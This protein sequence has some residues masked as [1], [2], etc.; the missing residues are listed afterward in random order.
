MT[1]MKTIKNVFAAAA[2]AG[3]F[4]AA[5]FAQEAAA[6][7]PAPPAGGQKEQGK[8]VRM[9]QPGSRMEFIGRELN[10]TD[11]QKAKIKAIVE[12]QKGE[13]E[14]AVK[15]RGELQKKFQAAVEAGDA[16]AAKAAAQE[17]GA[18]MAE[19]AAKRIE[20]KKAVEAVLTPEQKAKGEELRKARQEK[21]EKVREG[22]KEHIQNRMEKRR[23]GNGGPEKG[24]G[25]ACRPPKD[26][27]DGEGCCPPPPA[28]DKSEA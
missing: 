5:A 20:L 26:G 4:A 19:N 15:A 8:G 12:G 28:G 25:E 18:D 7:K 16:A 2:F 10:L 3:V 21:M 6:D 1:T 9:Q 23:E 13:M 14:K 11:D 27:N 22:A 24:D 17:I